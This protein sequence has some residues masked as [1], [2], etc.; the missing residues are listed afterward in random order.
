[1]KIHPAIKAIRFEPTVQ[2]VESNT[3]R[4]VLVG[5]LGDVIEYLRVLHPADAKALPNHAPAAERERRDTMRFVSAYA[6]AKGFE[7]FH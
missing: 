1:M 3:G 4:I 2:L 6:I 7:I 5:T